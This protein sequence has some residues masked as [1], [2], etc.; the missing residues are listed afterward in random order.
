MKVLTLRPAWAWAVFNAGKDVENRTWGTSYRGLLWI[1]ASASM[2]G[3]DADAGRIKAISGIEV[4]LTLE[5]GAIIGCVDLTRVGPSTSKW[6]ASGMVHWQL[7]SPRQLFTAID[8]KGALGLWTPT[9]DIE[10]VLTRAN[11]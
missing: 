4:P 1:H 5:C 8:C 3:A 10:K 11:W 9:P 2:S 6:A 7:A